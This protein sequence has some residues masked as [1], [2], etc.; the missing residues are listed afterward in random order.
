MSQFSTRNSAV[1][2]NHERKT[3][4]LR[5]LPL[6]CSKNDLTNIFSKYGRVKDVYIKVKS[7]QDNIETF[8]YGF[9]HFIENIS[10]ESA[11]LNVEAASTTCGQNV[12]ISWATKRSQVNGI[13][14]E[15][16]EV[17]GDQNLTKFPQ[18]HVA[19]HS[20]NVSQHNKFCCFYVIYP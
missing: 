8:S 17:S 11:M 20:K 15:E 1:V 14:S 2:E 16:P 4:Y 19:F 13:A 7:F 18:L 3:L 9:V 6:T 10:A 5:H 12:Q